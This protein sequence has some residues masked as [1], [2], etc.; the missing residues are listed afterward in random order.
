[1]GSGQM[2]IYIEYRISDFVLC[3]PIQYIAW[4]PGS[5]HQTSHSVQVESEDLNESEQT[6]SVQ[7]KERIINHL[8]LSLIN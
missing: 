6:Q 5:L 4:S 1:M 3:L 8:L 7:G 2:S